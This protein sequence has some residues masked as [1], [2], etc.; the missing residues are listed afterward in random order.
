A[1]PE[2]H[3]NPAPVS[4]PDRWILLKLDQCVRET[5][6][7]LEQFRFDEAAHQ[8]YHFIWHEFC[9]WYLEFSKPLL[10]EPDKAATRRVMLHVLHEV[11]RLLHPF[12]P[13]ITE[14]I[15]GT[16]FN[17]SSSILEASYPRSSDLQ[18]LHETGKKTEN[19]K[20]M[21]R[22]LR[23]I[24]GENN[25]PSS[26]EIT[27]FFLLKEKAA[28]VQMKELE[29]LIKKLGKLVRFEYGPDVQKPT[30]GASAAVEMG[31]LYVDLAGITDPKDEIRRLEKQS[32]K[33]MADL[34]AIN[35]KFENPNFA[36]NA[37][38][39]VVREEESRK[40]QLE[41]KHAFIQKE[42]DHLKA[43]S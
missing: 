42:I 2:Y 15:W 12:M 41:E 36:K 31:T 37:P 35:R 5:N 4:L 39:E 27:A 10:Q 32:E 26:R 43:L 13:F 20:E 34:A 11:L 1:K 23:N 29:P 3:K 24:R 7:S 30:F 16:V 14:A 38:E 21:I 33:V 9:D 22:G 19:L 17:G 25:I 28:A 8:V 6:N 18:D 40:K